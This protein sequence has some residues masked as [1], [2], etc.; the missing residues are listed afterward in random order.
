MKNYIV[1]NLQS[2]I[3][4]TNYPWHMP[5]HKRKGFNHIENIADI[6]TILSAVYHM[7]V[8]EV[9]GLDDLHMPEGMI[10]KS[11]EELAGVYH[12]FASYYLIN[13]S[14]SGIMTAIA[15]C[16]LDGGAARDIIVARNCHRSVINAAK[17]FGLNPIYVEPQK[18]SLAA[19]NGQSLRDTFYGG[20]NIQ[21]LDVLCR[22]RKG[23]AAMVVTSPTY[24]GVICDIRAISNVVHKYG[25]S[26]IVDEAHGAH[27]PFMEPSASAIGL[28]ADLVVH[29][30]HKTMPAMT[31]TALIH[32]INPALDNAVRKYK[33]ML[34]SSSPSYVMLCSM[35]LAVKWGTEYDYRPYLERLQAFR[36]KAGQLEAITLLKTDAYD[37]SRIVIGADAYG[38]AMEEELR[39]DGIICEMSGAHYVLLISTPFDSEADFEYLYEALSRLDRMLLSGQLNVSASSED[40]T[41]ETKNHIRKLLG[42]KAVH[43]IYVYPPGSYIVAEGEEIT[44]EHINMLLSYADSGKQIRGLE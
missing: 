7:D 12:T 42:T 6:E 1:E 33:S 15:A 29:S 44:E 25:I 30:L 43:N 27:L 9:Y 23:I 41:G 8:T 10:A 31:Q 17:L 4:G 16:C 11:Q 14:T 37:L 5:G 20:I 13:G 40:K 26:L 3:D 22:E 19:R 32:V 18:I 34:M 2:Y 24:E 36:K 28:G 21:E 35:E 38:I 39:K